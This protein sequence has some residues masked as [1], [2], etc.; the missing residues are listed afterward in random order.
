MIERIQSES[1]LELLVHQFGDRLAAIERHLETL[2]RAVAAPAHVEQGQQAGQARDAEEADPAAQTERYVPAT[3][4]RIDGQPRARQR[5]ALA[6]LAL[7]RSLAGAHR[8]SVL[9]VVERA[10]SDGTLLDGPSEADA[11]PLLASALLCV[12]ELERA[13]DICEAAHEARHTASSSDARAAAVYCRAWT[14]YHQGRIAAALATAQAGLQDAP[15]AARVAI[16]ACRLAQGNLDEAERALSSVEDPHPIDLPVLLDVRAQLRLAQMRPHDALAD[17]REAGR[18]SAGASGVVAWRSTA[19]LALLALGERE[20]A[21]ALAEE[22]LEIARERGLTRVIVRN[23][24]VLAFA[25][26]GRRTLD[27]L[28]EAAN[29]GGTAARL[30]HINALVDLGAAVRRANQR[31]AARGPLRQ[32]LEVALSG[33]AVALARRARD[34]LAA[35]GARP[36]RAMLSGVEALT[37]SERRVA[38]LA[39]DGLTTRQIAHAL[40]VTPKTVEF[41]LRHV[42]RKLDIPSS[43][44]ALALAVAAVQ[45]DNLAPARKQSGTST[46]RDLRDHRRGSRR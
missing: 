43:R 36:R 23:L 10:W 8:E 3:L 30:E 2:A 24:R 38:G 12:D 9:D 25:A 31:I 15:V 11:W 7:D 40:F 32:G 16:A 1:A 39:A 18:R 28:T 5:V 14:A 35:T 29:A 4:S 27:L 17:A 22:E 45:P 46:N 42:Y 21:R 41:H 37:P 20:R 44:E 19:A 13:V 34:E 26:E 6:Q 33:G